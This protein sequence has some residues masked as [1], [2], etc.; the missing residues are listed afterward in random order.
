[1]L[2]TSRAGGEYEPE[3]FFSRKKRHALDL[4]AIC[5]SDH[6]F[7]YALAGW[8]NSVHDARVWASTAI[9]KTPDAFLSPGEYLLG[10]S[11]YPCNRAVITPYKRPLA[12]SRP[13]TRFNFLHSKVRVDI[14][15]AFG[16][17]KGRW[18][19][20]NGLRVRISNARRYDFAVKSI[21]ACVVLHNIL[22]QQGDQW[23]GGRGWLVDRSTERAS[24]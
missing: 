24:R 4:C 23:E 18:Q 21:M 1:M 7:T 6:I 5:D 8:P 13:N 9:A 10:D 15:H 12:N 11:A 3:R 20:L 14:E 19:S 17:L 22:I 16:I 2:L